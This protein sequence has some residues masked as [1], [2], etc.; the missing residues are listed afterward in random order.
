MSDRADSILR[1]IIIEMI[2]LEGRRRRHRPQPWP[3]LTTMQAARR[4]AAVRRRR[5]R[6]IK[7]QLQ[8]FRWAD[9]PENALRDL[10]LRARGG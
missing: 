1:E 4:L 6:R 5:G 3:N 8:S 7:H 2:L 9:T 10:K